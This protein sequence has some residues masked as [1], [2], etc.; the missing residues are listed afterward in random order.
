MMVVGHAEDFEIR[1]LPRDIGFRRDVN[2]DANETPYEGFTVLLDSSLYV[3]VCKTREEA[4]PTRETA[5]CWC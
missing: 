2:L 1:R 3:C 4:T 5:P